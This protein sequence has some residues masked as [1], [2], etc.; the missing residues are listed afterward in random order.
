M[1]KK[2]SKKTVRKENLEAGILVDDM[3]INE[4]ISKKRPL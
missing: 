2:R 1:K 4:I 3:C